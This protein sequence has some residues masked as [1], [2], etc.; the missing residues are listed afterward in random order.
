MKLNKNNYL[1]Y[2]KYI[3]NNPSIYLI[4]FLDVFYSQLNLLFYL[5]KNNFQSDLIKYKE[6]LKFNKI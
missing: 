4:R 6:I 1:N 2:F 5:I 3:K